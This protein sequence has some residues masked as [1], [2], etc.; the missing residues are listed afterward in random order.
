M[1]LR[2]LIASAA[3]IAAIGI[4]TS[5]PASAAVTVLGQGI[6]QNCYRAAEFNTDADAGI[7]DC[8]TALNEEALTQ[9]DRAATYVN[10]GILR[11][12]NGDADAALADYDNGLR[13]NPQLAEG[14]V[15]RG[16]TY[17]A[18]KRYQDA[19]T[20]IDKGLSLGTKKA[21]IAY[22]DRAIAREALGDIKGAY[23][24]YKQAVELAPDFAL[25]I[26]QL[27][28]FKVVRKPATNGS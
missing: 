10:R 11:A 13:I 4:A 1:K 12:R 2:H 19:L 16:A 6:A 17:I 7:A 21:Y 15:D 26:Q 22:Y 28:R 3:A 20:D 14:Y 5:L 18:M 24:D 9:T 8:T 25:A 23:E 27:K